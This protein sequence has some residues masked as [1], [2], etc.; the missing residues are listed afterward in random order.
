MRFCG[1]SCCL[2][3]LLNPVLSTWKL[4]MKMKNFKARS[5]MRT[6]RRFL[7][8][9]MKSPTGLLRTRLQR[10]KYVNIGRKSWRKSATPPYYEAAWSTGGSA[11]RN[12]WGLPWWWSCATRC[13]LPWVHHKQGWL[14]KSGHGLSIVA[15]KTSMDPNCSQS[16]DTSK[17]ERY[18]K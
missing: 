10:R 8:S 14:R 12:G 17:V 6:N 18:S 1:T 11:R 5:M 3:I 15:H 16:Y 9:V 2:R 4:P 13:C 7:T